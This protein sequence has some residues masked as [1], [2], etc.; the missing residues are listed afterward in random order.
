MAEG[1]QRRLAAIVAID[2]AGYSRLM[3]ADEDGTLA[4]LKGHREATIPIG[5]AHGGRVVGTSGDGE[6]WEFPSITEAVTCAVE[7]QDLMAERNGDISEDQKMLYR[8]GINLGDVMIDGDDI[9][10]E[11][12]NVA[13][14]LEQLAEPGGICVSAMVHDGVRD[15]LDITFEDLGNIEV[16]NITRPIRVFRVAA[17]VPGE[18]NRREITPADPAKMAYAL[19][20]QPSIAV[21]PFDN[22]SG[23][24]AQDYLGDGLTENIIAVLSSSPN[25]F[26]IARISSFTFKGKPAQVQ[27]VAERLGVRYVL[28]GSVQRAGNRVRITAQLIDA[29]GG[30]HL[31]AERYDRELNDYFAV[32]DD[33]ADQ[34]FIALQVRLIA[35]GDVN[36]ILSTYGDIETFRLMVQ[37][38]YQWETHTPDGNREAERLISEGLARQPDNPSLIGQMAGIY[39]Q[40][41]LIGITKDFDEDLRLARQY[42]E[43]ALTMRPDLHQPNLLLPAL[44]LWELDFEAAIAHAD[45]VVEIAPANGYAIAVAGWVKSFC[46]QPEQAEVL[47]LRAMRQMPL[48]P[49]WLPLG[50][51][52]NHL[53]SGKLED[54]HAVYDGLIAT[55]DDSPTIVNARWDSM[56]GLAVIAVWQ[57]DAE[58]ARAHV[59][60][61][62]PAV[63]RRTIALVKRRMRVVRDRAFVE[64][65]IEALRQADLSEE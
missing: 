65:Y 3:G 43:K 26:V 42:C 36:R 34:I 35:G 37:S 62:E 23:D 55:P 38:G 4:D 16:K 12:V 29:I 56:Q 17:T 54:A 49:T 5:Q 50:L 19:P 48:H 52:L 28:E 22:L 1:T 18:T 25:L 8:I 13:A 61:L 33:I 53:M 59:Q 14:R 40:R 30:A 7:V 45:R 2:V 47:L 15:R 11:G 60:R 64:R 32:L 58:L 21:L 9:Y 24:P 46:S 41:T 20:E 51:A 39:W 10:G 31:W 44:D 6:L 63:P 27:E 57:D